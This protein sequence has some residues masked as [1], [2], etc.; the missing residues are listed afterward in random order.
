M[1]RQTR[2]MIVVLVALIA[3]GAASYGMYAAVSRIPVREVEVASVQA[4]LAAR[5]LPVGTMLSKDDVKLVPWPGRTPVAGSFTS[6]ESVVNRGLV[7]GVSE[8][9]VLIEP[10]LAPLGGGGGLPPTIT[11]GMRALS[12]KVNEVIGV[13]GFTVPGTRVD[14]LVTLSR[15]RDQ[16]IT[17]TVLSNVQVLTAGTR[18]DQEQ[19]QKSGQPIPSTVVTLLLVPEDAEKV[20]LAQAQGQIMLVLRNPLDQQ[21]TMTQGVRLAS[22]MGAASAPPVE[23]KVEGRR[24]MVAVKPAPVEAPKIYTVEAIRAAKRSEEVVR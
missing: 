18:Y 12:V 4:V 23:K 1:N 15:D 8:N 13:A 20:T 17:R 10:K 16:A 7:T 2:T 22:L 11:P 24:V 9:E 5:N 3:A 19:A 14:V 6:I 21:P